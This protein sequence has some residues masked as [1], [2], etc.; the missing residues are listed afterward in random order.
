MGQDATLEGVVQFALHIV[1]QDFGIGS[2]VERGEKS[3][4]VFRNHFVENRAAWIP[5]FVGGNS[6]RHESTHV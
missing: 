4:Q 2:V 6:W 3:L 5:G 1:G